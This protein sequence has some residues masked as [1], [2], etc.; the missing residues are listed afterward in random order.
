MWIYLLFCFI[1][2]YFNVI[3]FFS[4]VLNFSSLVFQSGSI[5]L[6]SLTQW[7]DN[8]SSLL[9]SYRMYILWMFAHGL[10]NIPHYVF[11]LFVF[12]SFALIFWLF[13]LASIQYLC[14][15]F[16]FIVSKSDL[17]SRNFVCLFTL[18][19]IFFLFC[20]PKS[21]TSTLF[22]FIDFVFRYASIIALCL[23]M[24][25]IVGSSAFFLIIS[26]CSVFI[27]SFLFFVSQFLVLQQPSFFSYN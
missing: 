13:L 7:D 20:T 15:L 11:Y 6:K 16:S 14:I 1:I 5:S 9:W 17:L 18:I 26:A 19:F 21:Y 4:F 10:T 24:V 2:N 22:L 27:F 3:H 8:N 25:G 23:F 12:L